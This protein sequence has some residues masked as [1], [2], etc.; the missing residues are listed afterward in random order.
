MMAMQTEHAYQKQLTIFEKKRGPLGET[1]EE[2]LRY[3]NHMGLG[4][5][6]HRRPLR[7]PML[8]RNA[9]FLVMCPSESRFCLM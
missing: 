3:F 7:A 9:P 2:D 6:T 1:G 4:F 5:R 8:T